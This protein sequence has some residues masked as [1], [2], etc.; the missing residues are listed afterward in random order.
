[1]KIPERMF[2]RLKEVAR[3]V[4]A[5][6]SGRSL[7]TRPFAHEDRKCGETPLRMI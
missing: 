6:L 3:R 5:A 4:D 7:K 2:E 1:M